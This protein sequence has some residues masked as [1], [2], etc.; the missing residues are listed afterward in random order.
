[1]F[2]VILGFLTAFTLTYLALPVII[3]IAR[4]KHLY[5]VPN[6]RSA[7]RE[8]TPALG[9][10]GIFGG[11]VCAVILWM[12]GGQFWTIQYV[13]AALVVI[14]FIG[15]KDDLM[16]LSPTKKFIGQV[17]AA[18]IVVYKSGLKVSSLYG[19]LGVYELPDLFSFV[20]TIVIIVGIINAFNLIDGINGLAGSIGLL[21]SLIWGGWFFLVGHYDLAVLAACLAGAITAFLKFNFTPA[22]IFMGDTG[23]MMIGLISAVFAIRFI[24]LQREIP[25][26]GSYSFNAAPAIALGI[27]ILPVFDTLRVFA[28]RLW[29]GRSPFTPDRAHIHHLLL[30][31][32][33]THMQ[34]TAVLVVINLIFIAV[35]FLCR[36]FGNGQLILMELTLALSLSLLAYQWIKYRRSNGKFSA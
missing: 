17:T 4:D 15:V 1:M 21:A 16:P 31:G 20:L 28:R 13:L 6:E 11:T 18:L 22:R 5:D 32:G 26:G 14:F 25:Q 35:A 8:P 27:L 36:H 24:E 3:R 12:P 29:Q 33:L 30:D 9:G 2:A 7:H 23:S 34:A 19:I 10:I